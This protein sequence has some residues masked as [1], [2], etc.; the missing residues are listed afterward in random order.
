MI[1]QAGNLQFIFLE[2][3]DKDVDNR[4]RGAAS[5]LAREM[6]QAPS[7]K[8]APPLPTVQSGSQVAVLHAD[9]A[10]KGAIR[11]DGLML[12]GR[13]HGKVQILLPHVQVSRV[14]AQ[15]TLQGN[16]AVVGDLRSSNGTFVNGRRIAGAGNDPQRRPIG[17]R[18]LFFGFYRLRSPA[19]NTGRQSE[20]MCRNLRR[21]VKDRLTGTMIRLLD[22][23]S[24]VIRPHEF[25]CLLGPSGSGKSTL[26]SALSARVPADEG[27]VLINQKDLYRNFDALKQDIAL[28]P[29][30]DILHDTLTV[31]SALWYTAKLR[32]PPDTSKDEIQTCLNEMLETV[33]LTKQ[34][35]TQIRHLS[36]GQI[37]RASLA[38]E[39][40]CKPTLL[41]LDEV[42]SGLDEQT[43]KDMMNLF[44]QLADAG[45]TVVCI[46]HSLANVER[47]CHLVVIL[48][49]GG[50]LAFVGTPSEATTYF[51]IE[52]LGDVYEKMAEKS[53]S[54]WQTKFKAHS[55]FSKYIVK[56]L[57]PD[58]DAEPEPVFPRRIRFPERLQQLTRQTILLTG[59]YFTI[60]LGD[61]QALFM[62]VVQCLIVAFLLAILFG[63]LADSTNVIER[64][65]NTVTLLFLMEISCFWFGCNN[66][67]K[68]IV[69]ERTIFGREQRLQPARWQLSRLEVHLIGDIELYPDLDP[70]CLRDALL[71]AARRYYWPM[72]IVAG[73]LHRQCRTRIGHFLGFQDGGRS[74]NHD[75]HCS[76]PA[77]Y[78]RRSHCPV[79][80]TC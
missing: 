19:A 37:K 72:V 51:G 21:I 67:A 35:A 25:V 29:Q 61:R 32:L 41:F 47:T 70:L 42:T 13:E 9:E 10:L 18:A 39:I 3:A 56:R 66:A 49:V 46:T 24:L 62:M 33:N 26:L 34:R 60:K 15:I 5:A 36:G 55:L 65:R 76:S 27:A 11:L 79:E 2:R 22:D 28:V 12:I 40:L 20:A 23:I 8:V 38:N 48:T 71:S 14:H 31:G 57:P 75:A 45:K 63:N 59:R 58:A 52:R 73:P 80:R 53:A 16:H 30:K 74:S 6:T 1:L 77:N 54:E 7:P 43:D 68:E 44:R 4:G 17:H 64:D 78:T 69:K 50:K